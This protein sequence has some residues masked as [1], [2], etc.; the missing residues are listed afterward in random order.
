MLKTFPRSFVVAA[1]ILVGAIGLGIAEEPNVSPAAGNDPRLHI[2]ENF[3]AAHRCPVR[4]LAADFLIASDLN[5]LDW[6]LLASISFVE[7]GG[8]RNHQY[9]N[10][11]G[12]NPGRHRF[13][14][15]KAA[16][17]STAAKLGHSKLYRNKDTTQI[18]RTYNKHPEWREHVKAVMRTIGSADLLETSRGPA[19]ASNEMDSQVQAA[20]D[21][22]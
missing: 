18:L 4:T 6:R 5:H 11:F 7:T 12:W 13:E 9:Y 16:I 14:S 17:Y 8:G 21:Q 15:F 3:F 22:D 20:K 19:L 10:I 2:L 1:G